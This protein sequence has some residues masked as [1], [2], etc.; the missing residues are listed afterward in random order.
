MHMSDAL[1]S[2]AVGGTMWVAAGAT[3]GTCARRLNGRL[4]DGMV[5]LMGVLGAFVF[6]AQMI[7][8]TLPGTG[9]SGHLGGGLLLAILLGPH[10]A[11]VVVASVL[12]VQALFF[13][14][15]GLLAL[16]SNIVNLGLFP[17]L[18]AYPLIYRPLAAGDGGNDRRTFATVLAAVVALQFGAFAVVLQ[19]TLSGLADLPFVAFALLM[20]PIHLGIGLVEGLVT[21]A[22]VRYV[23]QARPDLLRMTP[24]LA[25]APR[26][27]KKAL[28]VLLA[29]AMLVGG[30]FSWFASAHPDGLEWALAKAGF[31]E[32]QSGGEGLHGGLARVQQR[33]ALFPDYGF[34]SEEQSAEVA[35]KETWPQA[36]AGTS[37]AGIVGGALTLLLA[38][39][40]GLLL[41]RRSRESA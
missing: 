5:P 39:V 20:Q 24:V 6:A 41:K 32:E 13:A 15:G 16:G 38:A 3:L 37:A 23:G 29:A 30:V 7:N 34:R 31:E 10:A 28:A 14:D 1:L 4:E 40:V 25:A 11:F 21:A 17:C 8:F 19:T 26:R 35:E 2:P 18:L 22:V 36:D 12:T 27:R 9:S 33:L